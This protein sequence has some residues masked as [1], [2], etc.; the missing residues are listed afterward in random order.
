M[1]YRSLYLHFEC[2]VYF[3]KTKSITSIKEDVFD[4]IEQSKEYTKEDLKDGRR[5][6]LWHAILRV[7]ATL[8]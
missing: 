3:Y 6:E 8:M 2:G 4:N 5:L 1:D 7:F